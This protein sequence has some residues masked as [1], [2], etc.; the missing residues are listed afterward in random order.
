MEHKNE[1]PNRLLSRVRELATDLSEEMSKSGNLSRQLTQ[2]VTLIAREA[3]ELSRGELVR[4]RELTAELGRQLSG[5][6]SSTEMYRVLSG[7]V[8]R[9]LSEVL[10]RVSAF[11]ARFSGDLSKASE[12]CRELSRVESRVSELS[13]D[14]S[15]N[16]A[17]AVELSSEP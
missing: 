13:A 17:E 4:Q 5:A 15:R 9:E 1:S 10:S 3:G 12:V 11:R 6:G 8:S 16:L 14:L 7:E 2:A